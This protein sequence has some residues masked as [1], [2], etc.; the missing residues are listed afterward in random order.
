MA[1]VSAEEVWSG[2]S[3]NA[4][5]AFKRE[6]ERR[7]VVVTDNPFDGPIVVTGASGIPVKYDAYANA[8]GTESDPRAFCNRV[9]ATCRS[10]DNCTWDVIASYSTTVELEAG[11][12]QNPMERGNTPNSSGGSG[13][14]GP[15]GAGSRYDISFSPGSEVKA[16]VKDRDD[17][18]IANSAGD[19]FD[20]PLEIADP[21]LMM[22]IG[23]NIPLANPLSY[24]LTMMG[25]LNTVNSGPFLGLPAETVKLFTWSMQ[26]QPPDNGYAFWRETFVFHAKWNNGNGWLTELLDVGYFR[27]DGTDKVEITDPEGKQYTKPQLL[28][29]AGG[30]LAAFGA[31]PVYMPFRLFPKKD[32]S[33]FGL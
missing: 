26:F 4:D 23:R 13:G 27:I 3:G 9:R 10:E 2:R 33:V 24:A 1:I 29:G 14:G 16:A 25:Y 12:S 6:Y 19:P 28:D 18:P 31:A 30:V 8:G 17:N 20:P 21:Y 15:G 7:F 5:D 32:F 11:Q 22:T